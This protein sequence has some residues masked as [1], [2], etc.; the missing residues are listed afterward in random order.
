[1]KIFNDL[2]AA[3]ALFWPLTLLI[4][5]GLTFLVVIPM[6]VRYAKRT[7]RSKWRWGIGVFLLVYLPIFWDWIPTI[8]THKYYC[9]KEAGFWVY[10][11]IDQWK[12]ENQEVAKTLV[13]NKRV[14]STSQ[15]DMENYTDTNFLNQ[16]FNWVVKHNG[17]FLF[18]RWRHEQEVIDAKTNEVLARYV[19]FSTSQERQQAGW[20]GW[21]FWL[22]SRNCNGGEINKSKLIHFADDAQNLSNNYGEKK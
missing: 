16:R 5:I 6:A 9:E 12:A 21:K 15:G 11:T 20:N 17:R 3:A 22:S 13:A 8:V 2:L 19:D 1:M 7:G 4:L 14:P 10:K 18:N